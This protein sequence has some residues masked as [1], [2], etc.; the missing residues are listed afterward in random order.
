MKIEKDREREGHNEIP[1][2][3]ERRLEYRVEKI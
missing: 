2:V 1:G 3:K